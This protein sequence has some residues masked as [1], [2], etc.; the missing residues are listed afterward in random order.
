MEKKIHRKR[1]HPGKS[2]EIGIDI[3]DE[4][5]LDDKKGVHMFKKHIG[6]HGSHHEKKV[7]QKVIEENLLIYFTLPGVEKSAVDIR[8]KPDTIALDA[9]TKESLE[10]VMGKKE[11]SLKINL[12][13]R[14]KVDGVGAKLEDGILK[15]TAK[16][17]SIGV[18]IDIE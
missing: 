13:E 9:T 4:M 17:E 1:V 16:L 12:I 3:D 18:N 11:I 2:Y 14:I 8:I 5:L 7:F 6:K 10:D 15:V